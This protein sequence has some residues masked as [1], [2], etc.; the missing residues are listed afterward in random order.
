MTSMEAYFRLFSYK[1]VRLSHQIY[2][3]SVH[4]EHGQTIVFEEGH[5]EQG[6]T[7]LNLDTRLTGFFNL[8]K[9]VSE[10]RGFTYE[11]LPYTY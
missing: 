8:C 5:E 2:N 3:L 9:N 6:R 7:Q 11:R 10:A 1:I 4:D